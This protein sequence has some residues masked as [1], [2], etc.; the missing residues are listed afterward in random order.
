MLP[1][2][3]I[4]L[5]PVTLVVLLA[6]GDG[7][8]P[9]PAPACTSDVQGDDNDASAGT[10][11]HERRCAPSASGA[12]ADSAGPALAL[13]AAPP[14]IQGFEVYDVAGISISFKSY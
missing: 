6:C 11:R 10:L 13:R 5:G 4:R 1:R 7:P 3:R 8:A 2:N 14:K 9:P 12:A